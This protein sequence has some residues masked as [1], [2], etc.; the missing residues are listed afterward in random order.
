[1]ASTSRVVSAALSI[2]GCVPRALVKPDSSAPTRIRRQFT[3]STFH[4]FRPFRSPR[5][6]ML[7]HKGLALISSAD[8]AIGGTHA[9]KR[10]QRQQRP[11][12]DLLP[13]FLSHFSIETRPGFSSRFDS[14]S[15]TFGVA[16][17]RLTSP[18]PR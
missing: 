6:P 11:R 18:N 15:A 5:S 16:A 9:N 12:G 10:N 17:S 14:G 3:G 7:N 8:N 4:G 2:F 13:S 1:G